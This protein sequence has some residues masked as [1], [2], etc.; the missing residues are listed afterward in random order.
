MAMN[1][2]RARRARAW[3]GRLVRARSNTRR[4]SSIVWLAVAAFTIV[5]HGAIAES[6]QKRAANPD[7]EACIQRAGK[8]G[9]ITAV[10]N[11]SG[12][13]VPLAGTS[14]MLSIGF[15]S[16]AGKRSAID[17]LGKTLWSRDLGTGTL[18]SGFDLDRDGTADFALVKNRPLQKSCGA[19]LVRMTWLEFYSG[20][21]GDSLLKTSE[22]EDQC[23]THLNYASVRWATNSVLSGGRNGAIAL[24]P[25]Y[26]STGWY[27]KMRRG[28][29]MQDAF[30]LPSTDAFVRL[31]GRSSGKRL[32]GKARGPGFISESQPPNGLIVPYRGED[33]LVFFTSR[34]VLDYRVGPLGSSQLVAEKT[35][36]GRPDLA[37]RS[38]GVVQFDPEARDRIA[39]VAGTSAQTVARDLIAN[40]RSSDPWG[41]IERHVTVYDLGRNAVAQRFFG[42]A[43]D[44]GDKGQYEKRIVH[45]AH[46]FLAS[47]LGAA[48]IGYNEFTGG[49]WTFH[50]TRPGNPE[51]FVKFPGLF[52]WDIRDLNGDADMEIIA[53]PTDTKSKGLK[54][55]FP[56]WTTQ[57]LN[58]D[59]S[60]GRLVMN[61]EIAG[62]IPH[63]VAAPVEPGTASSSGALHPALT[64]MES[65]QHGLY[66]RSK[67]EGV[68]FWPLALEYRCRNPGIAV[69]DRNGGNVA[70]L[71]Q[72]S[73]KRSFNRGRLR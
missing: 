68:R 31:Y 28:Q 25:Q 51:D 24:T 9:L 22:L 26:S 49:I 39:V 65:G 8:G 14:D 61:Q 40:S 32:G 4:L 16:A 66:T 35:F 13:V 20:A 29:I 2:S 18:I 17:A 54:G 71:S 27:W 37:G 46:I 15:A 59:E 56:Q 38:Y 45:P 30:L 60:Q 33:R 64:G 52:V 53:S 44:G 23:H 10:R 11:G 58:F 1:N 70:R 50:V 19:S 12:T 5:P 47:G 63:L 42:S 36:S 43:H 55:Y 57:I 67:S 6:A 41:G 34:R 73:R 48:R 3:L 21:T 62:V 72:P 7:N 69:T